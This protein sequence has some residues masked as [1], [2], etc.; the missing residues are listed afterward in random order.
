[1]TRAASSS[2]AKPGVNVLRKL[3]Y[4]PGAPKS[5]TALRKLLLS[6]NINVPLK[7][8]QTFVKAQEEQQIHKKPKKKLHLNVRASFLPFDV[9]E[10]DLLDLAKYSRKKSG[11]KHILIVVD[12][13]TRMVWAKPVKTLDEKVVTDAMKE[14]LD[15]TLKTYKQLPFVLVTDAGGAYVSRVFRKMLGSFGVDHKVVYMAYHAERTIRTVKEAIERVMNTR[16]SNKW[17]DILRDLIKMLNKREATAIKM[18]PNEAIKNPAKARAN[19]DWYFK[20][21]I[22]KELKV[23]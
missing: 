17:I 16:G 11:Y 2:P 12:K 5:P 3:Y 21:I 4:E 10:S 13:F 22:D 9:W 6:E 7:E 14:I 15:S 18:S 19:Q 1:M 23:Y 20:T 8:I